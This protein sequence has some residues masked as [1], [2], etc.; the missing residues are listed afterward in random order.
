MTLSRQLLL[1]TLAGL[2]V[3]TTALVLGLRADA[4]DDKKAAVPA[5]PALSVDVTQPQRAT[6]P[7]SANANGNIAAWQEASVGTE[8]NG[9][10]LAEVRVN[11]GD[12]V[13][14]GQVLATFSPD[15]MQ[16]DLLQA[17]AAV[18]EAEAAMLIARLV[19]AVVGPLLGHGAPAAQM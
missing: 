2:A 10:R 12:V 6:I 8:A 16:A 13:K 4:A 1:S 18:A 9:L 19:V 17:R 15:T 14:R 5:K 3:A 7:V 11:I